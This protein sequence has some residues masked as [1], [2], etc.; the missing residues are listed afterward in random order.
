MC[1]YLD[2]SNKDSGTRKRLETEYR[3]GDYFD[4]V[5]GLLDDVQVFVFLISINVQPSLGIKQIYF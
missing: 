4:G 3:L 1:I 5:M 2:I